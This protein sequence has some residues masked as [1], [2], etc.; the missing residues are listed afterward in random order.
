MIDDAKV[1]DFYGWFNDLPIDYY[2]LITDYP[3]VLSKKE[4]ILFVSHLKYTNCVIVDD[5]HHKYALYKKRKNY[6]YFNRL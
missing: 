3:K 2:F 1:S 4:K 6:N 5:Y